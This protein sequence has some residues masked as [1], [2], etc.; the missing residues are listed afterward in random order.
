MGDH[1]TSEVVAVAW[2]KGLA[3]LHDA[4]ATSVPADVTAWST[5]GFV[6]V[7]AVGGSPNPYLPIGSP[8]AGLDLWAAAED[9]AHPPWGKALQLYEVVRAGCL[10]HANCGRVL[11]TLPAAYNDARVLSAWLIS[12]ARRVPGDPRGWAHYTADLHI[13]WVEV[14]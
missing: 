7:S 8:V 5:Y 2:L 9:S 10:D 6:Q 3:G 12:E 14:V 11:T 1:P 13:D 4:V